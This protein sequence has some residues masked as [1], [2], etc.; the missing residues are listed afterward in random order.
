MKKFI[1]HKLM[2]YAGLNKHLPVDGIK[3]ICRPEYK[4]LIGDTELNEYDY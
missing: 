3:S 4:R 1:K 2:Y